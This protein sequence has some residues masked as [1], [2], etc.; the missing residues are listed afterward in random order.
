MVCE[1]ELYQT[2]VEHPYCPMISLYMYVGLGP[3]QNRG[4]MSTLQ[5]KIEMKVFSL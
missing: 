3:F 1:D 2:Y 5:N 4:I